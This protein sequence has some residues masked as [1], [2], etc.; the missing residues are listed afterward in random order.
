MSPTVTIQPRSRAAYRLDPVD[1]FGIYQ[2]GGAI[3]ANALN[4]APVI[5]LL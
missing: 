5:S 2:A 1:I 4:Q 3:S